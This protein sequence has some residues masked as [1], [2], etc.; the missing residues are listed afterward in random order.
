[1]VVTNNVFS[2]NSASSSNTSDDEIVGG[3]LVVYNDALVIAPL[4]QSG[5][6]FTGDSVLGA[7]GAT[8]DDF[9]GG[10]EWIEGMDLT[11]TD[12]AFINNTATGATGSSSDYWT[13]GAGLGIVNSSCTDTSHT[14]GVATNLDVAGNTVTGGTAADINGSGIYTGCGP[15]TGSDLTL[16]DSTVSG[17]SSVAGSVA[18]IGG[19]TAD[20]LT[21]TNSIDTGNTGGSDLGGFNGSGGSIT[22]SYSDACAGGAALPG[23]GNLCAAP[24]LA[25]ATDVHET[26]ASPTIDKGSNALVPAGLST[27]IFGSSRILPGTLLCS[28]T[29]PAIVDIGA[30]EYVPA[31]PT[32]PKPTPIPPP[33]PA[34]QVTTAHV[35]NQQITLVTPA[36]SACTAST[37]KLAATLS[38]ATGTK[39][40][41]LKFSSAAF[42]IDKGI[43]HTTH[44]TKHLKD[45]KTK[46][47]KITVYEPNATAH[48][49]PTTVEL[50][51]TGLK[52]GTHTLKVI[53][54][55]KETKKEKHGKHKTVTVTKTVKTP[56][57]VC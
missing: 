46:H 22:A 44:K 25:R 30:A 4:T 18:G 38:S 6:V 27:D 42:Y 56:F 28:G 15:G 14:V 8:T 45:G 43:K 13:W 49:V 19:E 36:L 41:K 35:G 24:A 17:N 7:S 23:T 11:S 20:H 39:G 1:V 31:A 54:S 10:G 40:T 16:Q 53:L 29:V 33:A 37:G 52:A 50:S 57:T 5:N 12:D 2:G 51:L 48:H 9:G 26:A 34:P 55:Y 32:C 3:G 21:L 47:I